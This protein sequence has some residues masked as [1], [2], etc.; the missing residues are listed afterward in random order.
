[1]LGARWA[2]VTLTE[3]R[4]RHAPW[5][6][7]GVPFFAVRRAGDRTG[8]GSIVDVDGVL[9]NWLRAKGAE[10]IAL[11]PDGFIYAAASPGATLPAPPAGL[12]LG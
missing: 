4:T 2:V 1:M 6:A 3:Q 12:R 8:P 11:R 5:L 7:L 9:T 10:A